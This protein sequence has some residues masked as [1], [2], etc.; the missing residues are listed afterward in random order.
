MKAFL[1][2]VILFVACACAE[3]NIQE[4]SRQIASDIVKIAWELSRLDMGSGWNEHVKKMDDKYQTWQ[5]GHQGGDRDQFLNDR[6]VDIGGTLDVKNV[7][8][9]KDL[10]AFIALIA[11]Y[12]EWKAFPSERLEGITAEQRNVAQKLLVKFASADQKTRQSLW[13]EIADCIWIE[14]C[15]KEKKKK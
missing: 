3:E 10:K 5:E 9:T 8:N 7:K 4:R 6:L 14:K 12:E 11:L 2:T 15:K 1:L 13:E